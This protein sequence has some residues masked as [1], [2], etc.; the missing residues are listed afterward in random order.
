MEYLLAWRMALAKDLLRHQD[1]D[2]RVGYGSA[3]T[4]STAPAAM[5][6]SR[7]AAMPRQ[8]MIEA[9]ANLMR[10]TYLT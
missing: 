7:P 2:M 1:V 10:Q 9:A 6:A 8:E 5:L 4:L 3:S